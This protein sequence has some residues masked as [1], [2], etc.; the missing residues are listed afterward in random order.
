MWVLIC[1]NVTRMVDTPTN[2]TEPKTPCYIQTLW[3]YIGQNR[4]YWRAKFARIGI[5]NLFCSCGFNLDPMTL[6]YEPDPYSLEIYR[7]YKYELP[8]SRLSNVIVWQTYIETERLTDRTE[9]IKAANKQSKAL[10]A[11]MN[12]FLICQCY[13]VNT[14]YNSKQL[15]KCTVP[16]CMKTDKLSFLTHSACQSHTAQTPSTSLKNEYLYVQMKLWC[17]TKIF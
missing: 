16:L 3:L 15:H 1:C 2:P 12:Q 14:I 8:T 7:R 4:N 11:S 17:C 10:H 5:F 9:I 6:T 13:V